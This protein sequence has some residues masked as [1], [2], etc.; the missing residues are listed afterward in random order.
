MLRVPKVCLDL[1]ALA[2]CAVRSGPAQESETRGKVEGIFPDKHQIVV[3]DAE[4]KSHTIRLEENCKVV[5]NDLGAALA[6]L[7]VGDLVTVLLRGQGER[8]LAT[9]IRCKR[10]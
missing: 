3:A 8:P 1:F 10:E 6:D 4:G 9:E 2:V 5:I 7:Q